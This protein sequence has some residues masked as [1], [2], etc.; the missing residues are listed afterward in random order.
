MADLPQKDS[1]L[2]ENTHSAQPDLDFA[3]LPSSSETESKSPVPTAP[4]KEVIS[5]LYQ[6]R[7]KCELKRLLKHT[8][9][10][11]KGLGNIVDEEFADILNYGKVTDL[12][13]G[14]E[15]Q[16]RRWIFENGAAAAAAVAANTGESL[17]G[18]SCLQ[19]AGSIHGTAHSVE[20][21]EQ[22]SLQ[23]LDVSPNECEALSQEENF[24]VDVKAARKRFEGQSR[25]A[26]NDNPDD[27]FPGKV[28]VSEEEKGTVQKQK[29]GFETY[30]NESVK[31]ASPLNITDITNMDQECGEVYLGISR[32]KEI[33]EKGSQGKENSSSASENGSIEDEILKTNV[34]NRAQMFESMPL[35]QINWQN[36][37]ELDTMEESMSKT[38]ASLHG[39][40][41]IHS[42]GTLIEASEAAHVRKAKYSF[43]QDKGPEIQHEDTVMGSMKS[44][45]LQLLAR[46]NL[47]SLIAFLKEDDQGNV[48]IMN[49]EVPT[50]QLPFTVNQDKEYR[51]TI[52]VQVI[53]DL[54]GQETRPGKG[55]LIQECE[56]GLVD[57]LVYVLF[58]HNAHDRPDETANFQF[59]S[60]ATDKEQ[61]SQSQLDTTPQKESEAFSQEENFRVDVKATRK[62]FEGQSTDS[63]KDNLEHVFPDRAVSVQE[64]LKIRQGDDTPDMY[65]PPPPIHEDEPTLPGIDENRTS[66]VKLF[67]TCIEKGELD[68][69]RSLQKSPSEED[70]S[71]TCEE[72]EQNVVI[73]GNV[74]TMKALFANK[75]NAEPSQQSYKSDQELIQTSKGDI[76]A[77][78]DNA[79]P[80]P[81]RT[82][83][84]ITENERVEPGRFQHCQDVWSENTDK[85]IIIQAELVDV[86]EDDE[87]LNLQA[88]ILSLQ[89]VTEEA[90]AL[91][92]SIQDKQ[93]DTSKS[94]FVLGSENQDITGANMETKPS[95]N[96][97]TENQQEETEDALKGSVQA[98]L[99]SLGKSSFN[100]T[101]G[102]FKAAMIYRNSGKT[103]AGQKTIIEVKTA[104]KQST[105]IIA[106]SEENKTC[107]S[108][109]RS[110]QV[111]LEAQHEGAETGSGQGQ[112]ANKPTANATLTDQTP[113]KASLQ[114]KKTLG[115]K[116]VIPPKPDHLKVNLNSNT[117][118]SFGCAT[119]AGNLNKTQGEPNSKHEQQCA[120][121]ETVTQQSNVKSLEED[122]GSKKKRDQMLEENQGICSSTQ[123]PNEPAPGFQ[124]ALQN[125]GMKTGRVTPPVKPKRI[126][127]ATSSA[128]E[129]PAVL[130]NDLNDKQCEPS[131][132]NRPDSNV[133]MRKKKVRKESEEERRQRLSVH[134][135]EIMRG[136][137]SAAMEIF[138]Q[139][140]KQEELKNILSKVEEIEE[141][142]SQEHS[143]DLQRIFESVPD[144][145]VP[146]E[147]LSPKMVLTEKKEG[148]SEMVSEREMMSSMQVAYG[149]L[150]KASAAIITL[151]EQTLSRLMDIEETIRKAL[152][153]VSTLKS[154]S[155]IAGLSGLFKESMMAVSSP[156]ISGNIRKISIGSSKSPKAQSGNNLEVPGKSFAEALQVER[157]KPE[158]SPPVAKP[159]SVSPSSPSFISIQS[160]A[161][162]STEPPAPPKPQI[163][164]AGTFQSTTC[165]NVTADRK[166]CC[167]PASDRRQVSTLEVQTIPE[168]EKITGTKTIKEKY[169]ETDCFGNKFYSSKTSTVMTTQPE[170]SVCF[171][172]QTM[173]S[174]ATSLLTFQRINI[175]SGKGDQAST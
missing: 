110:E 28:V 97:E 19:E 154:D 149:D 48:E 90:K 109:P 159:R 92:R 27:V 50:H 4:F 71:V 2:H 134:M 30:Q 133:T 37:A 113:P 139:L 88:A 14:G 75:D 170:T 53:E 150:E 126:K 130:Q 129:I 69:L 5:T 8:C 131:N 174:P 56:M 111:T 45:L 16:S 58:R 54:L 140:R 112:P 160:A 172:R 95:Q 143:S 44:I 125:F 52:M 162:K 83:K 26:S 78:R 35:D 70:L 146:E 22:T 39:F 32:S 148:R 17:Q 124:S 21:K 79:L 59:G 29:R 152:Y 63:L 119:N 85:D 91:Q 156:P 166:L 80:S 43:I 164:K 155:D 86:A 123:S 51:T 136:N 118:A 11:M 104:V 47:N 62:M 1:E 77:Y 105:E 142:T 96:S 9:P 46:A 98:A 173:S 153:S 167:S 10:E 72:K 175:A 161:R 82:E 23:E 42:H 60:T 12:T 36:E 33:F 132:E 122:T 20:T 135:D 106:T 165:Y 81:D 101:K 108:S 114:S 102:D 66:N 99:D 61:V 40:N 18:A 121:D 49:V 169:E 41:V 7:Q 158:L 31:R 67:R 147:H 3:V 103:D 144:W 168:R 15:V 116:P 55:V 171:K 73:A 38:L 151:K 74:K 6:Q 94:T 13:Y 25:D 138:D 24:K 157:Q 100:V 120:D 141:D 87:L 107:L 34:R 76:L 115:P 84:N 64:V 65:T 128:A 145:A 163:P 127:M 68:Y 117:V 89:Q 137:A 57:T 93:Q